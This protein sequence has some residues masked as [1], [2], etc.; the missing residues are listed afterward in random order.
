MFLLLVGLSPRCLAETP[1]AWWV[2]L[3][4]SPTGAHRQE[5]AR[6]GGAVRTESRWFQAL[7]V[8]MEDAAR[9]RL[10]ALPFVRAIH[11]VQ[12][13]RRVWTESDAFAA[14][15]QEWV[16]SDF[17]RLQIHAD[18]LQRRTLFG[19]GVRIG[20]LDTGFRTTHRAYHRL[21]VGGTRDFI[22][23]DDIVAD[24]P[25]QD[26]PGEE[27]HGTEVL[28]I[29]AA[30]LP[31]ELMGVAPR[32]EYFLAKTEDVT[33]QGRT[34]EA[35]VEEDYWIAGLEWCVEKGCR[36]VNSSLGYPIFYTFADLDGATA[37]VT[38]AA[39]EA[40][41]RGTL[42]VNAAGNTNG[43]P[44]N[45][46]TLQGRIAPPADGPH[47]LTVGGADASGNVY[48]FTGQGPTADGR[49]KP[50]VLA[51]GVQVW[52]ITERDNS[53]FTRVTGTSAAT[54]LIT[55]VVAL[56]WQAF[57]QATLDDIL[58]AVRSTASQAAKPNNAAGYGLAD[59]GKAFETLAL[60][61]TPTGVNHPDRFE[62][63]LWSRLKGAFG[64]LG[65]PYPNPGQGA[66]AVP[67]YLGKASPV[68]LSL[69][70]LAGRR[71]CTLA[72][73]TLEQ[74]FHTLRWDGQTSN[75]IHAAT[76]IYRL[77][78]NLPDSVQ[79]RQVVWRSD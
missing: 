13:Y 4:E 70:D 38:R 42:V 12:K 51:L 34:F 56:L 11:P 21:Q 16:A 71:V 40:A 31:G 7:S 1:S 47:V 29:L 24:E 28:S 50:D 5:I 49:I 3:T 58:D 72:N 74:G 23:Q 59:A 19:E 15:Q 14:P 39:E 35:E 2:F 54:P 37:L 8:V 60:R 36:V 22:H 48:R 69:F 27:A 78:L 20:V 68:R 33:R 32:A 63:T 26:D 66:L 61:F 55:G 77:A 30:D 79:V 6:L 9:K 45:N 75:G 17:Q 76:G 43:L 18:E 25:G 64:Y 41:A 52:A 44:P 67:L 57:P 10:A 62:P 73:G 65:P 53:T 46:A